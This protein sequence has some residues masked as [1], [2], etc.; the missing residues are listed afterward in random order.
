MFI[1]NM[2]K[3]ILRWTLVLASVASLAAV[4]VKAQD[5]DPLKNPIYGPTEAVRTDVLTKLNYFKGAIRDRRYEEALVLSRYVMQVAPKASEAMYVN[6]A[7]AYRNLL[8]KATNETD[9]DRMFDSLIVIHRLKLDNFPEHPERGRNFI[10]QEIVSDYM[11]FKSHDRDALYEA[12]KNAILDNPDHVPSALVF[13]YFS[14]LTNDY[15]DYSLSTDTYLGE[16]NYVVGLLKDNTDSVQMKALGDIQ[17]LFATSGAATC[18]VIEKMY[19]EKVAADPDN[20]DLVETALRML[21]TQKCNTPFRLQ[22]AE[23]SYSSKPSAISAM[24]LAF[25]YEEQGDISKALGYYREAIE[26]ETNSSEKANYAATAAFSL[27]DKADYSNALTFARQATAAN[28][29]SA[30]GFLAQA[31]CY[32]YLAPRSC[33]GF[34]LKA[35]YWIVY[36]MAS[37][38]RSLSDDDKISKSCDAVM[39]NARNNFPSDEEI[40]F[41]N[42]NVNSAYTVRCG[43]V[44]GSTTV[45]AR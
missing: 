30:S 37:K 3:G 34:D 31:L 10:L 12:F 36:D 2:R 19:K 13:F 15:K 9:R 24:S 25:A 32:S 20:M 33:S 11:K 16:Y 1:Q 42:L 35:A 14:E 38:A 18:E 45:R 44:S 29:S 27:I 23:K 17:T 26:L 4:V 28:P 21:N 6:S 40:F 43:V 5:N 39:G 7:V 22:L 8:A 41:M